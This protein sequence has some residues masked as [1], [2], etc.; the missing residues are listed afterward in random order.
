MSSPIITG[1]V[2]GWAPQK[3]TI[4]WD[5]LKGNCMFEMPSWALLP[6]TPLSLAHEPERD[7]WIGIFR[8]KRISYICQYFVMKLCSCSYAI[9]LLVPLPCNPRGVQ[10]HQLNLQNRLQS[11]CHPAYIPK[12]FKNP[13]FQRKLEAQTLDHVHLYTYI[14]IYIYSHIY[15]CIHTYIHTYK[16]T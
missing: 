4:T 15:I 8:V 7:P 13:V 14:Y 11:P 2:L 1:S 9:S 3:S 6:A 5:G 12:G 16:D 10:T